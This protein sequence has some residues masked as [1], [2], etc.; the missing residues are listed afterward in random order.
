MDILCFV[1]TKVSRMNIF[2]LSDG[3]EPAAPTTGPVSPDRLGHHLQNQLLTI[4]LLHLLL[5][6][7]EYHQFLLQYHN[8]LP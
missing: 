3:G 1:R 6:H 8:Q 7:D 4:L 5:E 2:Y